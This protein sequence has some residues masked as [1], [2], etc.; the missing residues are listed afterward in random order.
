MMFLKPRPNTLFLLAVTVVVAYLVLTPLVM[1]IWNSLKT[2]PPGVPGPITLGNFTN[3]YFDPTLYPLMANSFLYAAGST[4]LAFFFAFAMAWL[5]ER[6]NA[7]LRDLA[8]VIAI[9]STI[10]PGMIASIA[11]IMLLHPRIGLINLALV[12]TLSL[13]EPPF[14]VHSMYGMIFVGGLRHVPVMFLLLVVALR[15]MDPS[16]EESAATCGSGNSVTLRRITLPLMLPA[17]AAAMIYSFV[18]SI[19]SFEVPAL[20]GI[21]ARIYV[22][23][24]K[25]YLAMHQSPPDYGLSAALGTAVLVVTIVGTL[26]YHRILR[27]GERY[28]T[29]TGKGYRP[30]PIDIGKWR[31]AGTALLFSFL[32]LD[33]ILP[34][35]ALI[36]ASL[37]PFYQ[38]PSMRAFRSLSLVSYLNALKYPGV[39]N[40]ASNSLFLAVLGGCVTMLLAAV[41]SWIVIRSRLPG[42][43]ILDFLAFA[44]I[45]IPGIVLGM[46]LVFLYLSLPIPIYGTLWIL[47]VA[48]ITKYMPWATRNTN[49]ALLQIHKELEEASEVSGA[50]W[51]QTFRRVLAPLLV[52]A[53]ASG[54]LYIFSHIVREVS[55]V[56]LLYSPTSNVLAVII[57]ELWQAGTIAE[58]GAVSVMLVLLLAMVTFIGRKQVKRLSIV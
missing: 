44:P 34:I 3:A 36:W 35:L 46:A 40:A 28:V 47:L 55:M 39:L 29:I 12:K 16:L 26:F 51:L 8:Y 42:R 1:L 49:S 27:R 58:V 9:V 54:F 20:I 30:C 23:S 18:T 31:Y 38:I 48:F 25:I 14:N 33:V 19:E 52:P 10:I 13:S 11:W 5:V 17:A 24:T 41:I 43:R 15:S 57:W 45:A 37:L 32:L 53:F 2:T 22:F 56:I 6:T 4:L 21:P 50:S 7:P